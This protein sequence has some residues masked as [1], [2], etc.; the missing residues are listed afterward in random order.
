MTPPPADPD[1]L[2]SLQGLAH[3][4][5]VRILDDLSAYGPSTASALAEKLGESSGATSYHLRQLA[6]HGFVVEDET[7]GNG[8]ERWWKR[9]PQP[10]ELYAPEDA[11][12]AEKAASA[13][14]ASE[15]FHTRAGRLEAFLARTEEVGREW[16][17]AATVTTSNLQLTRE[18]TEQLVAELTA[19]MRRYNQYREQDV[20][21]AR[22]VQL[23]IDVFPL[24]DGV[25][26]PHPAP[27][28]TASAS[29]ETTAS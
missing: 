28:D 2:R 22:P 11:G 8:R 4:L 17:D 3:P 29:P 10:I 15:W 14:V 1:A 7:R 13:L 25:E 21:G 18:Q 16:S 23:H 6:R 9:V 19:V 5:R 26:R 12:P 27:A 20:P 24:I